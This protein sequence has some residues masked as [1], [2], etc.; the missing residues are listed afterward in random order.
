MH[1]P[2]FVLKDT[3]QFYNTLRKRVD[4]YFTENNISQNANGK[5]IFKS[6]VMLLLYFIPYGLIISGMFG[7]YT[8]LGLCFLMGTGLAGI[9]MSVMH[10]ANHGAYSDKPFWNK[11]MGLTLNLVGGDAKNWITQHNILHHTYTNVHGIDED[12]QDRV[13][14][15]FSPGGKAKAIQKFQPIYVFFFYSL[16]SFYWCLLKDFIQ[17]R[18]FIK[19]QLY[20]PKPAENIK[21]WGGLIAWKV[22]YIG[23]VMVLPAILLPVTW[24]QVLLG[25]FCMQAIAG[26]ILS[27]VFQLAHTVEG[28]DFP[29]LNTEGNIENDWALHQLATTADFCRNNKFITYYV[30]G[31]NFQTEHHLFPKICHIH[32]PKIAPIVQQTAEEFGLKYLYNPSFFGA[33]GSHIRHLKSMGLLSRKELFKMMNEMG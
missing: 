2:K 16:L 14:M 26:I 4:A 22:F 30:G 24:W 23:Y 17:Y 9:G 19:K 6:V 31:L 21:N 27:V 12:I 29:A 3:T 28:T 8:M 13:I 15:R 5:M 11:F 32:Y 10:D 20:K 25:Y 1:K 7:T 18:T 33:V